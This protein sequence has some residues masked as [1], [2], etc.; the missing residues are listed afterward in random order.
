MKKTIAILA[1][2]ICV[3]SL[4]SCS[5]G[6]EKSLEQSS[7][8]S[9]IVESIVERNLQPN[10]S[11]PPQSNKSEDDLLTTIEDNKAILNPLFNF[12]FYKIVDFDS[13]MISEPLVIST[14][15][16]LI[17]FMDMNKNHL[18]DDFNMEVFLSNTFYHYEGGGSYIIMALPPPK[19]DCWYHVKQLYTDTNT[20]IVLETVKGQPTKNDTNAQWL[21]I[22]TLDVSIKGDIIIEQI[23]SIAPIYENKDFELVDR[24]KDYGITTVGESTKGFSIKKSDRNLLIFSLGAYYPSAFGIVKNIDYMDNNQC[25]IDIYFPEKNGLSLTGPMHT[26]EEFDLGLMIDLNLY[27][28]DMIYV[29]NKDLEEKHLPSGTYTKN[30]LFG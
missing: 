25:T 28:D 10:A 4:V 6:D 30:D 9:E 21:F 15:E 3:S 26:Q 5:I 16:E 7:S 8:S 2:I 23:E 24:L 27:E 22:D 19:V 1:T 20:H 17:N 14:Q 18:A 11:Q 29:T 12:S 13:S